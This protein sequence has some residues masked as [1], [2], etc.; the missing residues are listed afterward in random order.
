MLDL[1]FL[2]AP[3]LGVLV[4][5]GGAETLASDA[6]VDSAEVDFLLPVTKKKKKKKKRMGQFS[7]L[8]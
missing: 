1:P 8:S 4:F 2:A 7:R 5:F 6:S 3:A